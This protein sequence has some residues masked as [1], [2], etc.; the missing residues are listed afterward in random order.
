[1]H[2]LTQAQRAHDADPLSRIDIAEARADMNDA[3]YARLLPIYMRDEETVGEAVSERPS[4]LPQLIRAIEAV[5]VVDR[6]GDVGAAI[7]ALRKLREEVAAYV[8]PIVERMA[9]REAEDYEP[10][11]RRYPWEEF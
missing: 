11:S 8:S 7:D 4:T 3:A 2:A 5:A 10:P 9:T 1:M 6:G